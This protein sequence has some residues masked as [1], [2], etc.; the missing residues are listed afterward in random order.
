MSNRT[1]VRHFHLPLSA[2]ESKLVSQF[3]EDE[4]GDIFNRINGNGY[5][6]YHNRNN[7]ILYEFD[8]NGNRI[9]NGGYVNGNNVDP[10]HVRTHSG[11]HT[12]TY[13][14]TETH[15]GT[16]SGTHTGTH[17]GTHS[18]THS[19]THTGTH[20]GTHSITESWGHTGTHNE[21]HTGTHS[22]T[23]TVSVSHGGG[24]GDSFPVPVTPGVSVFYISISVQMII[25][26]H[27]LCFIHSTMF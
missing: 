4:N 7:G 10:T 16:H 23:H 9:N 26:S 5:N 22:G 8:N 13:T 17:S 18:E 20:S 27:Q 15:A 6:N 19:G 25:R 3:C 14:H 24:R 11:T 1:N 12:G 21:T 2:L